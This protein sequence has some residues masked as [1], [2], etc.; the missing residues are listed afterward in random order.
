M[1]IKEKMQDL[2]HFLNLQHMKKGERMNNLLS[3][4][5]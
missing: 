5:G 3:W 1:T 4:N 2:I